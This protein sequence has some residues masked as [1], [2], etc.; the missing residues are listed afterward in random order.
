MRSRDVFSSFA[1]FFSTG[2][3][4]RFQRLA[5][6]LKNE[7]TALES[8]QAKASGSAFKG[9][10]GLNPGAPPRQNGA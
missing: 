3:K 7:R 6:A 4:A 1:A 2:R 5:D 8:G 10:P 9:G